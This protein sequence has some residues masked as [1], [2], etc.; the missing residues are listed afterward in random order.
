MKLKGGVKKD[1]KAVDE[2]Y[3]EVVGVMKQGLVEEQVQRVKRGQPWL[4][5]ELAR[6]KGLPKAEREWLKCDNWEQKRQLRQVYSMNRKGYKRA[7]HEAKRK[8]KEKRYDDLE[9][10]LSNPKKWWKALRKLGVIGRDRRAGAVSKVVNEVGKVIEGEE[11]VGVWKRHFEKVMNSEGVAKEYRE[12]ENGGPAVQFKLLD[13]DIKRE[14]VLALE[15]MVSYDILVD[16]WWCL[17]NWCWKFGKT[18]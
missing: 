15:E 9:G 18:L 8:F 13:E 4:S 7:V 1:Q 12:S 6:E 16:V 2:N 10:L 17:F 14:V 5:R 3:E 11:A